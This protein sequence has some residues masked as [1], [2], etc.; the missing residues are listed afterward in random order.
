[1]PRRIGPSPGP[2]GGRKAGGGGDAGI[3]AGDPGPCFMGVDQGKDL[4]VVVGKR[5][6]QKAGQ[7]VHL[8]VYRDWQELDALMEA[9][10]VALCVVDGLPETRN[11]RGFAQRFPG[12]VFLNYYQEQQKGLYVWN[13]K[14]MTVVC[15]RTESLDASHQE[16]SRQEIILPRQDQMM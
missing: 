2:V 12:R 11:A 14:D 3:K 7:L 10:K 8:E 1:M 16:I 5:H 9:F 4:H 6:W 13:E 15:N